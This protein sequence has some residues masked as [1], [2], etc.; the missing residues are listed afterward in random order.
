MLGAIA[1]DVIGSI[2]EWDNVKSKEF[3]LFSS[4]SR[5]TDDSVLTIATM[6]SVLHGNTFEE[7]YKKW[8]WKYPG[9][10]FSGNFK[11]W[12]ISNEPYYGF[13]N[14]SA[15]RV[16]PVGY[17][18]DSLEEVL[19]MAEDSS[20]VTHNHPE[21]IKG[22]KAVASAIYLAK[23]GAT[24]KE[25]KDYVEKT[26]GYELGESIDSIRKWY[27]FDVSCQGSVPQAII[28]FM[29]SDSYE[30][31]VRNAISIGGDSDT[32]AC[33]TGGLAEA[34][35]KEIPE[36]ITERVMGILPDEMKEVLQRFYDEVYSRWMKQ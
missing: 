25:L 16:S 31:A 10:G 18:C 32:I 15:M 24:K 2:Y 20:A 14:G 30:D 4:K 5:F 22:A 9:A 23:N 11:K 26:F 6:D 13:S 3:E 35:Y 21:G 7:S 34:Y 12:A 28:S 36:Y 27:S 17:F 1:G 33:I 8:F 19:R 29:D